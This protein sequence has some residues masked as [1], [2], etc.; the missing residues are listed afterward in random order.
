VIDFANGLSGMIV[1]SGSPLV[2]NKSV[3]LEETKGAALGVSGGGVS[4]VFD[5]SPGV[6]LSIH[7]LTLTDGNAAGGGAVRV[8]GGSLSLEDSLVSDSTSTGLGGGIYSIGGMIT[9]DNT[10]VAD[11]RAAGD[12][13]GVYADGGSVVIRSS[14][15]GGNE[16]GTGGTGQGADYLSGTERPSL[17]RI[18]SSATTPPR[19]FRTARTPFARVV[20]STRPTV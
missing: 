13:G 14:T 6:G 4:R 8:N 11:N 19:P 3:A 18:P 16:A 1:L 2:I 5:I 12:G 20:R 7:G 17:C 9:L 10:T 15:L